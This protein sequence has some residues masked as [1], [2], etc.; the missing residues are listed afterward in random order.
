VKHR[1]EF[2]RS[3]G[4]R[5]GLQHYCKVCLSAMQA[6]S[7]QRRLEVVRAQKR[8]ASRRYKARLRA[9]RESSLG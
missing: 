2:Y 9:A 1:S 8:E 7:K 5:D 4:A 3:R 6:E